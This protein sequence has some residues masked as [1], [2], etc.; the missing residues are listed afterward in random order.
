MEIATAPDERRRGRPRKPVVYPDGSREPGSPAQKPVWSDEDRLLTLSEVADLLLRGPPPEIDEGDR[1]PGTP[2]RILDS[3]GRPT[4]LLGPLA[5][6]YQVVQAA[7]AFGIGM[8][9]AVETVGLQILGDNLLDG[10]FFSDLLSAGLP[11]FP[12]RGPAPFFLR[13]GIEPFLPHLFEVRPFLLTSGHPLLD[14]GPDVLEPPERGPE[15][16]E[17]DPGGH[18]FRVLALVVMDRLRA[19]PEKIGH[20][21]KCEKPIFVAPDG[22]LGRDPGFPGSVGINDGFP[23]ASSSSFFGCGCDFHQRPSGS[24]SRLLLPKTRW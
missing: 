24:G 11:L 20:L 6:A 15:S 5:G 19:D 14:P 7:P 13:E 16:R 2:I 10:H 21:G 12:F 17:T 18:P 22:V 8:A 1:V 9:Q 4:I 3:V 23:R